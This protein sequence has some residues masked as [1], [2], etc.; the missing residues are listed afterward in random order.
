[1]ECFLNDGNFGWSVL[2]GLGVRF[3]Q[4]LVEAEILVEK[5]NGRLNA[6]DDLVQLFKVKT[7]IVNAINAK[8]GEEMPAFCQERVVIDGFLDADARV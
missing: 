1:M 2:D 3:D 5:A 8:D 6:E 7:F 4:V